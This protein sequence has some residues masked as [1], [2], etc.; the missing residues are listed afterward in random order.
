[1][2]TGKNEEMRTGKNEEM[3]TGKIEHAFNLL[4]N[5]RTGIRKYESW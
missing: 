1:M 5:M 3:R 4:E 2:R